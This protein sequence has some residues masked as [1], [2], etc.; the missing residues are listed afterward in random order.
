[1]SGRARRRALAVVLL[2]L[3]AGLAG[4][5]GAIHYAL[6]FADRPAELPGRNVEVVVAPGVR[7]I[8]VSRV[9][10][11]RGLVRSALAFRLYA[12]YRGL[13]GRVR[14]GRYVLRTSM[15][16]REL[17]ARLV[18]GVPAPT[19][20]VTIPEGS[21]VLDIARALSRAGVVPEHDLLAAV[22]DAGLMRRLGVP[23][24]AE[25]L[26]G[27]LFP[28]TYR[29]RVRSRADEV[30]AMLVR[31]HDLV[32]LALQRQY[33]KRVY[34]LR[35]RLG[36]GPRE[37]V[38]LASII[39]KE[40]GQAAE[41]PLIAAAFFNRLLTPHLTAGLLQTDPTIIYGC[42]VPLRRSAACQSFA[43]RIRR[44]HLEDR[45]NAYNTYTHPGLPPGPISNPGRAAL[46][47]VLNPA[48]S[49]AV[50][51]VSRNDGTHVFSATRAEHELAVDRYQRGHSGARAAPSVP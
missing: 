32:Y 50:Y 37:I 2:T 5:W 43:G 34:W 9:M 48:H 21:N 6:G 14:A 36:W 12:S 49:R 7:F 13:T 11:E 45:E 4:A 19:A 29:L 25:S 41:R 28:D 31:R 23:G 18:K 46:E 42:T 24:A 16:P 22:R 35:R 3:A 26:E 27:F 47:A 39:E 17:L 33:A 8:T 38:T 15:T 1:M 40:T 30:V 20:L 51:F 44:I 10:R